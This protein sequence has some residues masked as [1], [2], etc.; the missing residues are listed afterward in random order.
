MKT[1]GATKSPAASRCRWFPGR[2][3]LGQRAFK[4]VTLVLL[5]TAIVLA[6]IRWKSAPDLSAA[7]TVLVLLASLTGFFITGWLTQHARRREILRA[8]VHELFMNL[9]VLSDKKFDGKTPASSTP[10]VYPRLYT[11]TLETAV[12]SGFFSEGGDGL[13]FTAMNGWRQRASELNHRLD[14]TELWLLSHPTR[15]EIAAFH[16]ALTTGVVMKTARAALDELFS[17]LTDKYS[18]ETGITRE[19][20][21]FPQ[22]A[23][24]TSSVN[25]E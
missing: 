7:V 25:A 4:L 14:I 18:L 2:N 9:N 3:T 21:L 20:V 17:L 12:A 5:C 1:V 10:P 8:L 22:A 11:T 23:Q 16:V 24:E 13:L 15:D 6:A 19:T